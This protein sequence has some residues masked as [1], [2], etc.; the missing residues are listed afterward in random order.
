MEELDT[1]ILKDLRNIGCE[2]PDIRNVAEL[3]AEVLLS[4][5]LKCLKK[6]APDKELP[7]AASRNMAQKVNQSTQIVNLLKELGYE[8]NLSYHNLLYTNEA[9]TR[10]ILMWLQERLPKEDEEDRPTNGDPM[11]YLNKNIVGEIEYLVGGKNVWAPDFVKAPA[12]RNQNFYDNILPLSTQDLFSPSSSMYLKDDVNKLPAMTKYLRSFQ[13]PI[14][15]QL[16]QRDIVAPSILEH[17]SL[18]YSQQIEWENEWN[19][20]GLDSGLSTNDYVKVKRENII[21]AMNEILQSSYHEHIATAISDQEIF[22]GKSH[23]AK[24]KFGRDLAYRHAQGLQALG[25]TEEETAKRTQKEREDAQAKLDDIETQIKDNDQ[26]IQNYIQTIRQLQSR[27]KAESRKILE[28]R[29]KHAQLEAT[30]GL[31]PKAAEN[32]AQLKQ[33]A[34]EASKRLI[35]MATEWEQHRVPPIIKIRETK[36]KNSTTDDSTKDILEDI[37]KM[38]AEM[39]VKIQQ[40]HAKEER[41]KQLLEEYKQLN[42]E[43]RSNYTHRILEM[44]KN[45]KKQKV[46]INKILID[47]KN[48][49][50]DINFSTGTLGRS[51]TETEELIY[52]DASKK[53]ATAS[54]AYK[55]LASM[56]EKFNKLTSTVSETG[57]VRNNSLNLED[58]IDKVTKRASTLNMQRIEEDLK[59]VKSENEQLVAK[60]KKLLGDK[61]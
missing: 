19:A 58:N 61:K 59:Q 5:I 54:A 1:L 3:K 60:I 41:Q 9:D 33:L 48:L 13:K 18:G 36:H 6:I 44:V 20:N 15:A 55:K 23:G 40:I 38:R 26:K 30:F 28:L 8:P 37:K 2:I 10:K 27:I 14:T 43:N 49:Q 52:K 56:N 53:D 42:K 50:K 24:T 46:E 35:S 22:G 32:I 7:R 29:E 25:E 57:S 12:I 16:D 4:C 39:K 51:F 21:K 31:L 47:T 45:V 34:D 11:S 17:L